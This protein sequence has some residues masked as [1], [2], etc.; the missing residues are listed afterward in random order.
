MATPQPNLRVEATAPLDGGVM[1]FTRNAGDEVAVYRVDPTGE[2]WRMLDV[3]DGVHDQANSWSSSS[4]PAILLET[5]DFGPGPDRVVV[6][7]EGYEL[8]MTY[9]ADRWFELVDV[10]TG[11]IVLEDAIDLTVTQEP[12]DGPFEGVVNGINGLMFID[13]G[14]GEVVVSIPHSVI[15]EALDLPDWDADDVSLPDSWVLATHDGDVWLLADCA[16]GD[17]EQPEMP[18]L[19]ATN[20]DFALVGSPGWEP[21]NALWQRFSMP[22]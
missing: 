6:Q 16:E 17:G 3:P 4:S 11:Q 22:G 14:T 15:G 13:P 9:G 19:V 2:T 20:A 5:Y 1:A 7:H 10:S 21:G 18:T 8:T 12:P